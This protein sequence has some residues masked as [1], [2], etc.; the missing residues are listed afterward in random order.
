MYQLATTNN[1][2]QDKS[3]LHKENLDK[4]MHP[5]P[6]EPQDSEDE[7]DAYRYKSSSLVL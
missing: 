2:F 3:K 5:E 6:E 7:S 4:L 1:L